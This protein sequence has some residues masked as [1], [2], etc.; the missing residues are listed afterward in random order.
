MDGLL[1][2]A[3]LLGV[4]A[5]GLSF[6]DSALSFSDNHFAPHTAPHSPVSPG[7][8]MK[9][10]ISPH[11]PARYFLLLGDYLK[12]AGTSLT[13]LFDAAGIASDRINETDFGL[14]TQQV[15]RLL[16]E[17]LRLTGRSDIGFEWGRRFKLNSHDILGYAM[18]SCPN[19]DQL[20]RLCSRY[21][22]LL[23]PMF[24]MQYQRTGNRAE[25]IYRPALPMS[26]GTLD[27]LQEVITVSTHLQCKSLLQHSSSVYDIYMSMEAPP[28]AARYRELAPARVHFGASSLPEVRIVADTWSL[29]APLPMADKHAVRVAEERCKA[30][31]L[32]HSEQGNWTEWVV[33]M[34]NE[35]EDCQPTLEELARILGISSRTLDRYL[36]KEE[37]SFRDLAIQVRN[38]RASKLLLEGTLPISQIAYRLGFTDVANFCRAFRQANGVSPSDFRGGKGG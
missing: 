6:S 5:Q 7:Q 28:H 4:L 31:L 24:R 20:L 37:S 22:R 3:I 36:K 21:Y 38:S 13:D 2:V 27:L 18:L 12:S 10:A 15:D 14:N 23:T 33:M 1:L 11:V 8:P 34:L 19:I 29:D 9:A 17:A 32:R 30:L 16:A 25:I 35:A 26:P